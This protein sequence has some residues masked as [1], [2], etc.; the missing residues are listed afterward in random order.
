MTASA[1]DVFLIS[2]VVI[3]FKRKLGKVNRLTISKQ[4]KFE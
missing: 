4:E 2:F 3:L 1:S